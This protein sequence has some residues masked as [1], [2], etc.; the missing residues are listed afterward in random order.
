MQRF[1]IQ[2]RLGPYV[3]DKPLFRNIQ[4]YINRN[5]PRILLLNLEKG[6]ETPLNDYITIT[7]QKKHNKE[8]LSS[9]DSYG[10]ERFDENV[11]EVCM[12]LVHNNKFNFW[13]QKVIVLILT[14][15]NSSGYCDFSIAL[16][17]DAAREKIYTIEKGLRSVMN[18]N[19][20]AV[21]L[22]NLLFSK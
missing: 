11:E 19:K 1:T 15:N 6:T 5:I 18:R 4:A 3:I 10:F 13:G 20:K 2:K 14:F 21:P 7:I 17:D 8:L 9:I 12:E 22:M 16:S